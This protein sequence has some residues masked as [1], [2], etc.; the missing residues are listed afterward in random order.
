MIRRL[1][2][3]A[4]LVAVLLLCGVV[5]GVPSAG[6][7]P[8][9]ST[10]SS[11]TDGLARDAHPVVLVHGWRGKPM[12]ETRTQLEKRM[13]QGWQYLL[14]DYHSDSDQWSSSEEVAGCLA[15]YLLQVSRQHIDRGGDGRVYVVT[16]SMGGL[17]VRFAVARGADDPDG[18]PRVD[19]AGRVGGL[20]T[21]DTPH[22]GA[23]WGATAYSDFV[24]LL[25]SMGGLGPIPEPD[26]RASR[27]LA[28]HVAGKG[29]PNG[30]EAPPY[31][32]SSIPVHQVE[33]AATVTRTLFG[34]KAYDMVVGGDGLVPSPSSAGYIGSAGGPTAGRSVSIQTVSCTLD[35]PSLLARAGVKYGSRAG[36]AGTIIGAELGT[37]AQL[38]LDGKALDAL[39][40]G[41]ADAALL[42]LLALTYVYMPCGHDGITTTGKAMDSVVEALRAQARPRPVTEVQMRGLTLPRGHG[43]AF[44]APNGEFDTATLDDGHLEEPM[45]GFIEVGDLVLADV[46]GDRVGDGIAHL[47]CSSGRG[48]TTSA[49]VVRTATGRVFDLPYTSQAKEA[50]PN[51]DVYRIRGM[52]V[53]G[54]RLLLDADGQRAA[55]ASCCPSAVVEVVYA[56]GPGGPTFGSATDVT[57]DPSGGVVATEQGFGPLR[58]GMGF[59]EAVAAAGADLVTTG[60]F[61]GCGAIQY[62]A[63]A[64]IATALVPSDSGLVSIIETPDG[65]RTDRGAADGDALEVLERLYGQTHTTGVMETQAGSAAYVTT[66]PD[67][68][69]FDAGPG[70]IGF[71]YDGVSLGPPTVGGIPGFEYCSGG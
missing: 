55:E 28:A 16:H 45:G 14:F 4:M 44:A 26:T 38:W 19:I 41:R 37:L 34:W 30:C 20:T 6:A 13:K 31:L 49:L 58:L 71:S 29:L 25:G 5:V 2:G 52:S 70:L 7:A 27:C 60:D 65:T 64:G 53:D 67:E 63:G 9:C 50:L 39:Q 32:P 57:P 17:A 48:G 46:D 54:S 61:N 68:V 69:R 33:G 11:P 8:S 47:V 21:L 62:T 18:G 15:N 12:T 3:A 10:N 23:P 43:C 56:L 59:D 66:R 22:Q 42:E 24:G 40:A 1:R 36:W 35:A 51:L